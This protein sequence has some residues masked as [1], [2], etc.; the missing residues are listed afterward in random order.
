[1]KRFFDSSALVK[2]YIPEIGTARVQSTLRATPRSD[3]Y[4][5]YI[6]GPEIMA[7]F[8]RRLRMGDITHADYNMATTAFERHF[9]RQYTRLH[10][11]LAVVH[12]AMGLTRQ[13]RLRG[14]DA[15]QLAT[16]LTLRDSLRKRGI[17]DLTFVFADEDLCQAAAAEG[18]LTE[19]PNHYP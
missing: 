19:N 2:R 9:R 11:S 8:A 18:L 3:S 1:M 5:A 15:V 4:I 7:A 17:T 13:H 12:T 10:L 16:A 6:T 14:Y